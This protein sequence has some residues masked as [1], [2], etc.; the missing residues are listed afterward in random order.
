[1]RSLVSLFIL[2]LVCSTLPASAQIQSDFSA[3]GG[4][5]VGLSSTACA[6]GIAGAIRYNS[7]SGGIIEFCNGTSW[8]NMKAS[9]LNAL[10]DAYTTYPRFNMVLGHEATTFSGTTTN[11]TAFGAGALDAFTHTTGNVTAIGFEALTNLTGGYAGYTAIGAK[12]MGRHTMAQG[13][14]A[15]GFEASFNT[16]TAD[17]CVA[18]G[19]YALHNNTNHGATGVGR[20]SLENAGNVYYSVGLGAGVGPNVNSFSSSIIIGT[21]IHARASSLTNY[22]DIGNLIYGDLSVNKRVGINK[23]TQA[24][25]LDVTGDI[26]FTG[27]V[28][29]ISDRRR[30]ENIAP[31]T[32]QTAHIMALRPVS[33]SMK[34]DAAQKIEYGFI[35]QDVEQIF[36]MLV[37]VADDDDK[38]KS[39]NYVGL[40]APLIKAVQERQNFIDQQEVRIRALEALTAE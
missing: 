25:N 34:A 36:P 14:A 26:A 12:A 2:T 21:G 37:G 11:N 15:L 4:L 30:K 5:R 27:V 38:T 17:H 29:D 24:Y 6:A 39:L 16:Q 28:I 20:R 40:L 33:Y 35:A 1:M 9:T 10:S 18:V 32:G 31:L 23:S 7:T 8:L 13:C 22:L 19:Y 3:G